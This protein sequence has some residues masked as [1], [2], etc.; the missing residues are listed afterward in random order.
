[1]EKR[2]LTDLA[3]EVARLVLLPQTPAADHLE[4]C[5][6]LDKALELGLRDHASNRPC[7]SPRGCA[8]RRD[9]HPSERLAEQL[10]HEFEVLACFLLVQL[11]EGD[12]PRGGRFHVGQGARERE[13]V[14]GVRGVARE[15]ADGMEEEPEVG[16]LRGGVQVR[17]GLNPGV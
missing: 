15:G 1:M 5:R 3:L 12:V 13:E 9:L 17:M 6:M 4:P 16:A 8:R 14:G 11:L 10:P 7:L 2:E